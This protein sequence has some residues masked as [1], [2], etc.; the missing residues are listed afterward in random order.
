VLGSAVLLELAQLL[1]IDRHARVHD[2]IEKMSGG[3]LGIVAG[4]TF[5]YFKRASLVSVQRG[6]AK[7]RK[8]DPGSVEFDTT[9]QSS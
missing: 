3:T 7:L 2:A 9:R 5:L 8:I 4:R 6:L 1:T